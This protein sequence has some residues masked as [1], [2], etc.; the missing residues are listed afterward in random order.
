MKL[1]INY[2]YL[3]IYKFKEYI[4]VI[5]PTAFVHPLAAVT[6]CVSIG[7]NCYIGP[8]AAIRGD[9][10]EIEIED[11]CNV[12]EHCMIHMFPGVKVLLKQNAHIGHGAVIH[13]AEIGANCLIGMNSVI[14]DDSIIGDECIIGAMSF[15]PEKSNI[16]SRSLA[17]GSP[18]KIIK[19]VSDDMILWKTKG[20]ALY[21]TL[22][23]ECHQYLSPC[24]PLHEK[25]SNYP[26]PTGEYHSW[27]R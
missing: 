1:W 21:Q 6:G 27:K 20:T 18:Y 4:P 8:F 23:E 26:T 13:G 10:G 15:I 22:A 11:G 25:P 16:P 2:L 19:S 9:F 7:K 17:V 5:H 3:M 24:E 14:M 12:Q